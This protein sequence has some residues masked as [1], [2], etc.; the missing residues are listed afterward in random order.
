MQHSTTLLCCTCFTRCR[1]YFGCCYDSDMGL[2][3]QW[4]FSVVAASASPLSD[5]NMMTKWTSSGSA[6]LFGRFCCMLDF[7]PRVGAIILSKHCAANPG[8][9]ALLPPLHFAVGA[10]HESM[11]RFCSLSRSCHEGVLSECKI[12]LV[13]NEV[14][15]DVATGSKITSSSSRR[16]MQEQHSLATPSTAPMEQR[17]S[18][19]EGKARSLMLQR[20]VRT[21]QLDARHA[22]RPGARCDDAG[23]MLKV[24]VGTLIHGMRA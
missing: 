16:H 18:G 22:W 15:L 9:T 11:A 1:E 7:M 4:L 23:R 19:H 17:G 21:R 10:L 12:R 8:H 14:L 13:A 5:G 20:Y 24:S 3:K 2:Q 6:G